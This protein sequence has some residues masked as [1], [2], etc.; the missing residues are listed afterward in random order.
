MTNKNYKFFKEENLTEDFEQWWKMYS[1]LIIENNQI[2][3]SIKKIAEIIW[4]QTKKEINE[5]YKNKFE[6]IKNQMNI[7][8]ENINDS[9]I[10]RIIQINNL[11]KM[12]CR[13]SDSEKT[14]KIENTIWDINN[15]INELEKDLF[16]SNM[17]DS[18]KISKCCMRF[19]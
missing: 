10:L 13:Y 12:A 3:E 1:N 17:P 5:N 15:L 4:I 9:T 11:S 18:H 19:L 2:Q 8:E 14:R 7:I 6:I 16:D